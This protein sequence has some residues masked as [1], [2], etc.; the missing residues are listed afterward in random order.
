MTGSS[1][2]R[3]QLE[4]QKKADILELPVRLVMHGIPEDWVSEATAKQLEVLWE[5]LMRDRKQF[6]QSA[7]E[8]L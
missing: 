5:I 8:N 2:K 3:E 1:N 6:N 4:V 7:L